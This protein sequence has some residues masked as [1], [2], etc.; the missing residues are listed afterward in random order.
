[1]SQV[2]KKALA[3]SLK[4]LLSKKTLDKITVV[5]LTADCG[6]NRQTFYYHF[7]DIYDLAE[8]VV[9]CE[10]ETVLSEEMT[11]ETWKQD[12]LRVFNAALENKSLALNAYR[13]L[14]REQMERYLYKV[15]FNQFIKIL[16][17]KT[18][19]LKLN[20]SEEER[21]FLADILKH[22]FVGCL[23]DWIRRGLLDDPQV[24][25]NRLGT[26]MD[27]VILRAMRRFDAQKSTT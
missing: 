21:K 23:L 9:L 17:E 19:E 14:R 2:T 13:S 15:L 26:A 20:V 5:E 22:I 25:V 24:I 3:A 4:K 16:N 10:A 7:K 18:L 1:M 8:W 6:V 12:T 27:G 11:F